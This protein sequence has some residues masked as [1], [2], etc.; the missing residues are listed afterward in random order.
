MT[1]EEYRGLVKSGSLVAGKKGRLI[2]K[3]D[4]M[5]EP[6]SENSVPMDRMF[7]EDDYLFI[8]GEVFSSKNSTQIRVKY[9]QRSKW[10]VL[11]KGV[12]K[13]VIPFVAKSDNAKGYQK[14]KSPIYRSLTEDFLKMY[15]GQGFPLFVEMIFVRRT[16]GIWDFNNLSQ[17]VC[18]CMTDAKWI[19]DDSTRYMYAVPP[20]PPNLA[21]YVDKLNP[22]VYLKV[23]K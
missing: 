3:D 2:M 19:P 1:L 4:T 9:A 11:M 16:R 7:N 17:Q 13:Y 22:G 21:H 6:L 5:P 23:V 14:T 15:E 10:K 8:A 18:D 12:W 20:M